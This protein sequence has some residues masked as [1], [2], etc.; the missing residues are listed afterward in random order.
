MKD[1][2]SAT[3]VGMAQF[4]VEHGDSVGA[5]DFALAEEFFEF[6]A[7]QARHFAGF[8]MGKDALAIEVQ[9]QLG[10]YACRRALLGGCRVSPLCHRAT[11]GL[12]LT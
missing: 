7:V 11:E 6:E 9:C 5:D 1:E 4:V 8:P 2:E 12:A 3:T 10:F